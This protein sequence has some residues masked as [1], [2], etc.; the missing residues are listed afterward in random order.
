[1]HIVECMS[2]R[3]NFPSRDMVQ[4]GR[5][6]D[7]VGPEKLKRTYIS[8]ILEIKLAKIFAALPCNS[9]MF[10]GLSRLTPFPDR[11]RQVD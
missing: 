3:W 11:D 5:S 8:A 6:L 10:W 7:H 4:W 2:G 1:M 9:T